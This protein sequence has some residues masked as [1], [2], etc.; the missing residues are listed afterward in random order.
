VR[1]RQL[2]QWGKPEGRACQHGGND[3]R[4]CWDVYRSIVW[5]HPA[6]GSSIGSGVVLFCALGGCRYF[7]RVC[8]LSI[9]ETAGVVQ[10][11]GEIRGVSINGMT[12]EGLQLT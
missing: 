12:C 6:G 10:S 1:L 2:L 3:Y 7:Y 4:R 8:H 5:W 11:K 9:C